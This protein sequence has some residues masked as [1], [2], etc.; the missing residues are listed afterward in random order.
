MGKSFVAKQFQNMTLSPLSKTNEMVKRYDDVIDLSIG[1]P[2]YPAP[3]HVIHKMYADALNGHTRY[4]A[5]LGDEELRLE[6]AAWYKADYGVEIAMDEMMITAGGTHALY[7]TLCSILNEGEEV[8]AIAPYYVYYTLQIEM[9]KGKLVVYNTKGEDNF[10]V[11][12]EELEKHITPKT[13]AIIINSPCNPSGRV[14]DEQTILG[15]LELAKK[16][17]FLVIS[18]DI[19]T[20]LVYTDRYKPVCAHTQYRDRIITIYSYSK[21]YSMTGFRLGH[22]IAP[23][24]II[25]CARNLNEAVNFTVSA[26]V[27]RAG[28]EALRRRKDIQKGIYEEY[29]KRIFYVYERIQKMHNI[30]CFYP[31]GTFYLFACIKDTGYSSMDIWEKILDEAHVLVLPGSG[32]GAAGEGYIRIACTVGIEQLKVA[33]DRLEKMPLFAPKS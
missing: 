10:D 12:L 8:I 9:P 7:L 14:Y 16:H 24:D 22:I 1:D 17:D 31:E 29:R 3:A 11:N 23:K 26:M 30:S 20:S 33:F 15:I 18:D 25:A 21:D 4:T 28:I 19:Y 2:D 5:F 6:T 32:F 27:Q 13:K